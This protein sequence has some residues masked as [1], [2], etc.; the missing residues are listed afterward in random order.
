V[1]LVYHIA[2][3]D[4]WRRARAE[5]TYT[6]STRGRTLAEVGFIHC[7]ELRQVAGVANAFYRDAPA[8]VLLTVDT[9]RLAAPVRQESAPGSGE[10]F[11]HLYGPLPIDAV[12][13]VRPYAPDPDGVFA[14]PTAT[15][16]PTG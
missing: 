8:L 16:G 4:D 2:E 9:D 15:T 10:R 14:T 13:G 5:G 6:V 1:S 3:A 7:A 12:I 11:P